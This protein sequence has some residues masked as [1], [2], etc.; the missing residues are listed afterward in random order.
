MTETAKTEARKPGRPRKYGAGRIHAT[1]RFTAERYAEL[2]AA[3]DDKGRSV[4]EEVEGRVERTF[5]QDKF[6]HIREQLDRDNAELLK[7]WEELV[8]RLLARIDELRESSP[9][10]EQAIENAVTRA[11]AKAR[12]TINGESS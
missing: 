5:E 6:K 12:L 3:A 4:S 8:N 11:L 1:V 10:T 9:L 7:I 2:K